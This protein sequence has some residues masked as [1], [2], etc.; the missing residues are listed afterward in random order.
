MLKP[1]MLYLMLGV[2]IW[3]IM[4][5]SDAARAERWSDENAVFKASVFAVAVL[6]WPLLLLAIAGLYTAGLIRGRR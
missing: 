2:L 5:D 3:T 4:V 6:C 1:A